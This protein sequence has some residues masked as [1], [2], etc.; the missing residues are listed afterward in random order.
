MKITNFSCLKTFSIITLGC[1][2]NT[3]ESNIIQNDLLANGLIQVPFE[4]KADLYV[5]NT[6][7]VTNAAD[8]KS[9]NMIRRAS[10][11]NPDAIIVVCGCYSQVAS[12]DLKK[13]FGID[14]LL[15][16]KYKN[17]IVDVINE[18]VKSEEQ[19]LVK[20]DNLLLEK[21]YESSTID[22]YKD[23]TRAF[24]KIQDGCNFMCSY[25][26]IPFT[27]GRQRS[28]SFE[29]ILKEI[30]ILVENGYKEIVLTGVNT[31]GYQFEDKV[32]YDLLK[33]IYELPGNFRVRVSSV[34]PFQISDEIVKLIAGNPHRF[35][36][37]WHI[38]LQSGSDA[39]L[40]KMNRK[41]KTAQFRELIQKIK[42]INPRTAFSTDYICGFPTETDADHETSLN[43]LREIGFFKIHVFPYS[44]R[45]YTPAAKMKQVLAITKTNR[46]QDV[47]KLSEELLNQYLKTF[48]GQEVEVLFESD[49]FGDVYK[50]HCSEYFLVAAKSDH[51]IVNQIKKVRIT[52]VIMGEALGEI[53][54]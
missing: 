32:F 11:M 4:E 7:S 51:D 8:S 29:I 45:S 20:V 37:H 6:C 46:V 52:K 2:V 9:R 40:E 17:N 19:I 21:D 33:A 34:E 28:K 30:Q 5:I 50:G 3:Y 25:C 44:Q 53:I 36:Q 15:G 47:I 49:H 16:N 39:V 26:I 42:A 1:K 24:V 54:E 14:I 35:A 22:I 43:F 38:C 18:Y 27:R 10:K 31:A 23:N 13:D 12:N 48:I 41:Y